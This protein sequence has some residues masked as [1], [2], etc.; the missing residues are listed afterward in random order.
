[1]YVFLI[2]DIDTY[3]PKRTIDLFVGV[4]FVGTSP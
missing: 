2:P 1:M 4:P 3:T